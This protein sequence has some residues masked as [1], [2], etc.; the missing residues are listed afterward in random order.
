MKSGMYNKKTDYKN[1]LAMYLKAKQN[2]IWNSLKYNHTIKKLRS[3]VQTGVM[4]KA[5]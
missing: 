2:N 1:K 5:S 3:C 4:T